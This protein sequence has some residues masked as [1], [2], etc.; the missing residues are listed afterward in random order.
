MPIS[1]EEFIHRVRL[2]DYMKQ[3]A[4][5]KDE[6]DGKQEVVKL[7]AEEE[8]SFKATAWSLLFD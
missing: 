4:E 8:R 6:S 5:L 7:L 1:T 3:L 2:L